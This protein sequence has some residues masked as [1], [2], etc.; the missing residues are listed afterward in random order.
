MHMDFNYRKRLTTYQSGLHIRVTFKLKEE[1]DHV[2]VLEL[3]M[4]LCFGQLR[5]VVH[6]RFS[7]LRVKVFG[8]KV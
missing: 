8:S 5:G 1:F 4:S 2:C 7:F 6:S 3:V